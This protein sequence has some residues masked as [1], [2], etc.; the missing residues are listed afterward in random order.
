[1]RPHFHVSLKPRTKKIPSV[2]SYRRQIFFC[3]KVT[4]RRPYFLLEIKKWP[5]RKKGENHGR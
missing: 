3:P 4:P 2:L 5:Y 1:M